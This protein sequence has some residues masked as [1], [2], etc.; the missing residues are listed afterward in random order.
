MLNLLIAIISST[1]QKV[2][3]NN[4]IANNFEKVQIVAEIDE[5]LAQ[6]ERKT[7]NLKKYLCVVYSKDINDKEEKKNDEV[8]L[9]RD[10]LEEK[11]DEITNLLKGKKNI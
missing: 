11:I 8:M 6:S 3:D 9:R 1:F 4:T 5:S 10:K 2:T 7:L